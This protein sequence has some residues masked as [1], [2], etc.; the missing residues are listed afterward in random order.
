MYAIDNEDS[1]EKV[2]TKW[3]PFIR[4]NLLED[5][6]CPIILVGNKIDL[7]DYTTIDAMIEIM[8]SYSE[9]ESCV[10]CSAKTLKN[11]TEM[12][13]YAQKAV[14]HPT[15]PLYLMESQDLTP[16]CKRALT[17]IFKICD[18]DNDGLL[19]DSELNFFQR[20]C[21]NIPPQSG[22]LEDVKSAIRK[23]LNNGLEKNCITLKGFLLLHCLFIQKG[24]N[25]TIWTVLR[26][27]GYDDNLNMSQEYL[28][29]Q[30][31]ISPGCTTELSY[32]G[33]QFFTSLFER[34]DKDKDGAL[35]PAE[36]SSLFGT[37]PCPAWGTEAHRT[38]P[39]TKKDVIIIE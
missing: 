15:S 35:C 4:K 31:N 19:N 10:E 1:L 11:I 20:R 8:K 30:I 28:H 39:C 23:N 18:L 25:E 32:K 21:F 6:K 17:R 12:F 37:C 27:F 14:L 3:L 29:P 9:I 33:Q 16:E 5:Q 24:R 26:K 13:Y 7:V 36:L 2:T 38:V 22:I 34:H